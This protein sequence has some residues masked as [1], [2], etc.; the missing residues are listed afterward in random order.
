[1]ISTRRQQPPA[2]VLGPAYLSRASLAAALEISE[3]TVD[4][5]VRRGIIPKPVRLSPGCV[6][7]R[8]DTVDAALVTLSDADAEHFETDARVQRA[9]Q[10]AKEGR[11]GGPT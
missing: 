1:V 4:E 2:R 5:M 8:W 3:S 9:I 6:R 11:R 10:A 7:W